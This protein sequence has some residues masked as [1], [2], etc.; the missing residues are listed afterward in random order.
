MKSGFR[1]VIVLEAKYHMTREENI[2]VA[3]RNIVDYIWKSARLEGPAVTYPDTE[4]IYNGMGVWSRK[5]IA[6]IGNP[7]KNMGISRKGAI[8]QRL[9]MR[10]VRL[11]P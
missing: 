8:Q 1:E 9:H 3:K 5:L 2:F 10:N 7:G 4:A 6:Q 11:L